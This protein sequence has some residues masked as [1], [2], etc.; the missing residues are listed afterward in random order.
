M[1][2]NPP[3]DTSDPSFPQSQASDPNVSAWVT[4]NAGSGKTKVL[5]DRVAR[6]LLGGGK[7]A[8]PDPSRILCLTYTRAAAA[9]MQNKLFERLGGWALMEDDRLREEIAKLAP[10]Q[11]ADWAER[12]D[13]SAARKLFAQALETPGGLRIQTIHAFCE[14]LLRRFPFEAG[15]PPDFRLLNEIESAELLRATLDNVLEA[16]TVSEDPAFAAAIRDVVALA[17]ESGIDGLIAEILDKRGAFYNDAAAFEA[18]ISDEIGVAPEDTE[19]AAMADFHRA[20]PISV[21][22]RLVRACAN[23]GVN[24][25]KFV[26]T[27]QPALAESD[28]ETWRAAL[29]LLIHKKDGEPR[30]NILTAAVKNADPG[31]E[32]VVAHIQLSLGNLGNRLRGIQTLNRSRA[33]HIFADAVIARH[34]QLKVQTNAL[35]FNDLILR[36]G[37]LLNTSEA[38]DWVRFKLDGGVDHILVDEAQDTA[39]DQWRV[40][41]AIA[42]EFFAGDSARAIH[43]TLFVVGDEKQSIFSFQGAAPEQLAAIRERFEKL[44]IASDQEFSVPQLR[45]SFRSAPAILG[46]VDQVFE[47]PE[48]FEGVTTN[49]EPPA[50]LAYRATAPGRVEFWPPVAPEKP[51]DPPPWWKPVDHTPPNA[52]HLRLAIALID[53][54][55]R[56]LDPDNPVELA[57]KGRNIRAGDILILVRRRNAFV[58]ALIGGLK[59]RGLPVSGRDRMVLTDEMAVRDL[60]ALARFVLLPEDDLTLATVLRSPI[61]GLSDEALFDL[62]Y[63]RKGTL[64]RALIAARETNDGLAAAHAMLS[65]LLGDADFLRPFEFF[66]RALTHHGARER[67]IV[68][69]GRETVDPIDEFLNRTLEED[70]GADATLQTFVD[71]MERADIT[72]KREME[73]GRDEIRLMTVHGAK[74]LESNIVILPDICAMPN[75]SDPPRIE[76]IQGGAIWTPSGIP[77]VPT[78]EAAAALRKQRQDEEYRRLLYVGLT[79][80]QDWLVV[81]GWHGQNKPSKNSWFSLMEPHY[82]SFAERCKTPLTAADGNPIEGFVFTNPGSAE[83]DKDTA[84]RLILPTP[85][86]EALRGPVPNESAMPP[87]IAPSRTMDHEAFEPTP[88]GSDSEDSGLSGAARGIELHRLLEML[89]DLPEEER[90]AAAGRIAPDLDAPSVDRA[91]DVLR[92]PAFVWMFG[93]ESR[94]EITVHGPLAALD[95]RSVLGQIDRLV[96]TPEHIHIID[97]KSG[98]RPAPDHIPEAYLRQLALYRAA[99]AQM[100]ANQPVRATLLWIDHNIA[101]EISDEILDAAFARLRSDP[102]LKFAPLSAD[103]DSV[104]TAS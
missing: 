47:A 42:E 25:K 96:I 2:S 89:A 13:L 22:E 49:G 7:G 41:S 57:A 64:W 78:V 14:S 8:T 4:A 38:S 24:E 66:E 18:A 95:G 79:R 97:F 81:C 19:D 68:R 73:Q 61:I 5:I 34:D 26:K 59:E 84:E 100:F 80:A 72:I 53:Q 21:V 67:L 58:D 1:Q 20:V 70:L 74:G 23:G 69:L 39:P 36:A 6:L 40:I 43:R 48:V 37:D 50:H 10:S 31:I 32:D 44:V 45:H 35:D 83:P 82:G 27:A 93:P 62:S 104:P 92:N 86:P 55:E 9:T 33:L 56:W 91:L 46:A 87:P 65:D 51:E 90:A 52:P 75:A 29:H 94:S 88:P 16:A 76:P 54:I 99:I 101:D 60:L 77:P 85:L 103:I 17:R 3:L 12:T 71:R 98:A 28:T 15:V 30:K 102:K 11:S 63:G